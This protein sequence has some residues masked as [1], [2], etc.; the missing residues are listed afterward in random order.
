MQVTFDSFPL[1]AG[2]PRHSVFIS[3]F[4][5]SGLKLASH[6]RQGR[7][8]FARDASVTLDPF[9]GKLWDFCLLCESARRPAKECA[10]CSN[11]ST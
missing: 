4:N 1:N 9:K 8:V 5:A 6:G 11:Q 7:D 10:N 2:A 3:E